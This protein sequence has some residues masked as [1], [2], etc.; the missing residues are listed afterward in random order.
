MRTIKVTDEMHKFLMDLSHELNTQDHRGTRMPY[1]Y[2]VETNE[3]I[4]VPDGQ[5]TKA[6]HMD[7]SLIETDEKI[8]EVIYEYKEWDEKND[9]LYNSLDEWEIEKTLESAGW[10]KVS[11]DYK[12]ELQNAFLTSK[13][14]DEH[15]RINK[16]NLTSPINYLSGSFRNPELETVLKF[17]CELSGGKLHQ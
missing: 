8:K 4:A 5:G 6:W 16:H 9:A 13:A 15:I 3:Q 1:F 11:Y 12:K 7:G 17:L 14:C 2:Q 10:S